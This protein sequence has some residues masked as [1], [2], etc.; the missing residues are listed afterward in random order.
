MTRGRWSAY[1]FDVFTDAG[2]PDGEL[3]RV[4]EDESSTAS[5]AL[6]EVLLRNGWAAERRPAQ[7]PSPPRGGSASGPG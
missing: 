6:V 7:N 2:R 4:A 1:R 5:Y 3:Y